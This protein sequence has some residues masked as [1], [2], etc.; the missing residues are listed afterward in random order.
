MNPPALT[1]PDHPLLSSAIAAINQRMPFL[2]ETMSKSAQKFGAD[3]WAMGEFVCAHIRAAHPAE[4]WPPDGA[5]AGYVRFCVEFI[6]LQMNLD[7]QG[8]YAC[9]AFSQAYQ[10]VYGQAEVMLGYYLDALAFS[11]AFW[12]NHLEIACFYRDRFLQSLPSQGRA[13]ELG[14]GHGVYTALLLTQRPAWTALGLDI[15][16]HA[17]TYASSAL[18]GFEERVQLRQ[19]DAREPDLPD[20]LADAVVCGEVL[21]H[22]ED[23][24]QLLKQLW[25]IAGPQACYF[26]T[27][28]ANAA[29]RDHIYLFDNVEQIRA[30]LS[31]CGFLIMEERVIVIG[32]GKFNAQLSRTPISYAAIV[33]KPNNAS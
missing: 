32:D 30:M 22:V 10:E 21:E 11:T 33:C 27:T 6:K 16:P 12:P 28:A 26:I 19:G 14:V 23:P 13:V 24:E 9:E 8:R 18:A 15:S 17:L 29:S 31:H 25:R 3:F 7:R 5:V 2:K 20:G 1:S 4:S